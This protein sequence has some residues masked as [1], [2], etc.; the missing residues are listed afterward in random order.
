[1]LASLLALSSSV[2]LAGQNRLTEGGAAL[3]KLARSH[4]SPLS[5][6]MLPT[7]QTIGNLGTRESRLSV[8]GE[9]IGAF[10]TQLDEIT[11]RKPELRSFFVT[12]DDPVVLLNKLAVELKPQPQQK[13]QPTAK[14]VEVPGS[15]GAK[16]KVVLS[17][18]G[19]AL[20]EWARLR[21]SFDDS[22]KEIFKVDPVLLDAPSGLLMTSKL[23]GLF[24]LNLKSL[25]SKKPALRDSLLKERDPISFLNIFAS[26]LKKDGDDLLLHA[27]VHK[28]NTDRLK[29]KPTE[30]D[31]VI[32]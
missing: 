22:L 20:F 28:E 10:S 12:V 11:R 17:R 32:S 19:A 27:R 30:S 1:M 26:E 5:Q 29:K 13:L 4:T 16:K 8:T 14:K 31:C 21:L 6:M 7:D 25:C 3:L 24:S 9:L 15:V 18:D 2:V 23:V